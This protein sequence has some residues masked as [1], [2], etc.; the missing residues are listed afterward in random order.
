[1][2]LIADG[3]F[4][5]ITLFQPPVGDVTV[6]GSA[7]EE[8]SPAPAG[9]R[10]TPSGWKSRPPRIPLTLFTEVGRDMSRWP[11][12]AHF[13][14][15]AGLCPDND[16]SGGRILWSGVRQTKHRVGQLFR[17]AAYG[18]HNEQGQWETI[19]AAIANAPTIA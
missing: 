13:V 1:M 17:L 9:S 3:L 15:W 19:S 5:D 4:K 16:I 7:G 6:E 12:A 11:T 10:W 2:T 18:L 14:S 8:I